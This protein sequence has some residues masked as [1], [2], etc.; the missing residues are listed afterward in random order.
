MELTKKSVFN[1]IGRSNI[2]QCLM[3]AVAFFV[4]LGMTTT[5]FAA[6]KNVGSAAS[7][8][9][10]VNP[11]ADLAVHP[12]RLTLKSLG[13]K[14]PVKLA[15]RD[16]INGVGFSFHTLDIVGKVRVKLKISYSPLL[17]PEKSSLKIIVNGKHA[18]QVSLSKFSPN[19]GTAEFDVDTLLLQEWNYLSYQIEGHLIKPCD[20]PRDPAIWLLINNVDSY[21][22]ADVTTLPMGNDLSF[23]PVPFFDK[24]DTKNLNLPI[25][26]SGKP[27]AKLL[28]SAGI[29]TSWFGAL[30][31]YR[32]AEFPVSFGVI[33]NADAIVLATSG[34]HIEGITL[35][36][37]AE[38][39]VISIVVNPVNPERR[40]FLVVGH[41]EKDLIVA[42]QAI[43]L[44]KVPLEGESQAIS[45][46]IELPKRVPM[47]APNWLK[48]NSKVSLGS[49]V[50]PE[51]LRLTGWFITPISVN[52]NFPPNMFRSGYTTIP[53]DLMLSSSN[54]K[55]RYLS[56]IVTFINGVLFSTIILDKNDKDLAT[57][58]MTKHRL[59]LDIPTKNITG[60]D[61]LTF[62]F[63]FSD[64]EFVKCPIDPVYDEITIDPNSAIDLASMPEFI[65][66]ANLSYFAYS[67]FPFTKLADLSDAVVALP[68]DPS[69]AEIQTMLAVLG[70]I[71]NKSGY[72][73]TGFTFTSIADATKVKDKNLL[74]IGSDAKLAPA[75]TEWA[76]ALPLNLSKKYQ[77][78]PNIGYSYVDRWKDW[79][80]LSAKLADRTSLTGYFTEFQLPA[81]SDRSVLL[82]SSDTEMG[83]Q[84]VQTALTSW[85]KSKDFI[86][87]ISLVDN[88]GQVSSYQILKKYPFGS[89]P[90]QAV[91]IRLMNH[92]P[93]I[94]VLAAFIF[95]VLFGALGFRRLEK[96]SHD[97]L[98]EWR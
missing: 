70:H 73:A 12:V 15:S 86:G 96:Q 49:L 38:G 26:F 55:M 30:S 33:P 44:G 84:N 34:D 77:P 20:D 72:P 51:E 32:R 81:N 65:E 87:D 40:L 67:A 85:D 28:Q 71:G 89:L 98:S 24:H 25:V 10:T 22:E 11:I 18:G 48:K 45:S 92:N 60:R 82:I 4:A 42:A 80:K 76:G 54:R 90:V 14:T 7:R 41:S 83:L 63:T 88:K 56:K 52:A 64:A 47:D 50:K 61:N 21:I 6:E 8:K 2:N 29:L 39:S 58:E 68:N 13:V 17:S 62:E 66:L 19:D 57:Q 9:A 5:S 74:L 79:S 43:T 78:W 93:W 91:G 46:K 94:S 27:S 36:V 37:V 35:P 69:Q 31:T 95:A 59:R 1:R 97:R 53:V 23:F 3:L 16:G 75:R